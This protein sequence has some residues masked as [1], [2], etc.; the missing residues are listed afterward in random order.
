VGFK[1]AEG[2]GLQE[3]RDSKELCKS[4]EKSEASPFAK[5]PPDG[6]FLLTAAYAN[7]RNH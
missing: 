1:L 2:K 3:G 4:V 6:P 5:G 7:I